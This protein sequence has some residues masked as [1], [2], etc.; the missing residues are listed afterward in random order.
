M[1]TSQKHRGKKRFHIER[2]ETIAQGLARVIQQ[3][4]AGVQEYLQS[5]PEEADSP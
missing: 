3:L 2:D 1:I 4:V 5:F